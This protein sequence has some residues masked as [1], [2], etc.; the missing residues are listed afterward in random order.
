MDQIGIL[1]SSSNIAIYGSNPSL[2]CRPSQLM[3]HCWE[4]KIYNNENI[5]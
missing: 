4:A 3:T 1:A 2:I 5:F